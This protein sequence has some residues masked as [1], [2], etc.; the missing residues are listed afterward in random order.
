MVQREG[1]MGLAV[2]LTVGFL[3][4]NPSYGEVDS[5]QRRGN[6]VLGWLG[7]GKWRWWRAMEVSERHEHACG[8]LSTSGARAC[9]GADRE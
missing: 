7:V 2:R 8:G 1:G 9:S 4:G 6:G 3:F 5:G